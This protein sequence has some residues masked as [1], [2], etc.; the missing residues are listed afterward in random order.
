MALK[1]QV[2]LTSGIFD[3]TKRQAALTRLV[4]KHAKQFKVSTV[5]KMEQGPQT[6]KLVSKRR[7]ATFKRSHR[8]SRK[9]ERPAKQTGKLAKG[10]QDK[11]LSVTSAEVV[12][13]ATERGFDY[14]EHL[15]S[16]MGRKIMTKEDA[17]EAETKMA[18]DPEFLKAVL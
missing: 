13:T 17:R 1:V 7:G 12:S 18:N 3:S 5:Q 4:V 9:G 10:I 8:P 15:Q 16:K 14:P 2:N 6:G 11:K